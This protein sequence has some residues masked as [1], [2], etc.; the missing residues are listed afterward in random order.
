VAS[1]AGV[2]SDAGVASDAGVVSDAGVASDAGSMPDA[3]PISRT[4]DVD[5]G[6]PSLFG[7]GGATRTCLPDVCDASG[8]EGQRFCGGDAPKVCDTRGSRYEISACTEGRVC[9][10]LESSPCRARV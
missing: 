7:D 5:G 3:G 10:A 2:V 4:S 6:D 1:D 9:T 8:P